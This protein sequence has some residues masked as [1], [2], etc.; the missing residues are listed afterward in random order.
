MQCLQ[1]TTN[2]ISHACST[3]LFESCDAINGILTLCLQQ[4]TADAMTVPNPLLRYP[5]LQHPLVHYPLLQR[6]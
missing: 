4:Q 1:T 3:L 6:P 2:N 5:L